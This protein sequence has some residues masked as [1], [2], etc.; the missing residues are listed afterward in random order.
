MLGTIVNYLHG[1]RVPF[2]L[3]SYPNQEPM[4]M[5]AHPMPPHSMLVESEPILIEGRA[6]LACFPA[7]EKV[8][9]AALSTA[10]GSAAVPAEP[11]DL[12]YDLGSAR[13]PIPPFGELFGLP[14]ILDERLTTCAMLV[15]Q[16]FG[17]SDFFEIAYDDW[18]RL[19]APRVASF[20]FA[21]ELTMGDGASVTDETDEI[22]AE[23]AAHPT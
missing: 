11:N 7:G 10:L 16:A 23:P 5:A 18:A 1:S 9:Y 14:I 8:D 4:P 20:A 3:V 6:A 19:E 17:G 21:G 2:R 15:C 12:P 13:S 22:A